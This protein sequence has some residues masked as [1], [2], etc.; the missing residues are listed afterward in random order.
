MSAGP[1]ATDARTP[2]AL[3]ARIWLLRALAVFGIPTLL[4]LGFE[5]GLRQAGN[6]RAPR[7]LISDNQ[8]AF[9]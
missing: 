9:L 2:T 3:S 6:G 8:R 4:L 1:T 5:G 7:F